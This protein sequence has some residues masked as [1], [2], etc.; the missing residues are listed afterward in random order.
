M[1]E[2]K[3]IQDCDLSVRITA[4]EAFIA[5]RFDEI[6]MEINA[7]SQ[8]IDMTEEALTNKFGEIIQVLNAVSNVGE[9]KSGNNTGFEL[10]LVVDQTEKAT[11]DIIDAADRID[12]R[13]KKNIDIWDDKVKRDELLEEI[14]QDIQTIMLSCSFQDLTGQ[15]INKAVSN[16]RDAETRLTQI[17]HDLGIHVNNVENLSSNLLKIN[18]A[19]QDDVD[20]LFAERGR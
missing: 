8:M 16:I 12:G 11:N 2:K 1:E 13:L 9:G 18:I 15:R 5:R 3:N 17:L 14:K 7:T 10:D 4:L 6:S 19:S 20:A